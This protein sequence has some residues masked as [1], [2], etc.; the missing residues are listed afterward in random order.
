MNFHFG[1]ASAS[2]RATVDTHSCSKW[3]EDGRGEGYTPKY[4]QELKYVY[5][6]CTLG[7]IHSQ[8]V[9]PSL[10]ISSRMESIPH[11]KIFQLSFRFQIEATQK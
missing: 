3:V 9:G 10:F 6:V 5:I 7:E 2:A 8:P 11:A 1:S 4:T